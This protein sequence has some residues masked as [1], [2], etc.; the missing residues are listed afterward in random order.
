MP[1]PG[2][3]FVL[4]EVRAAALN[5]ADLMS[6]VAADW[7]GMAIESV[8]AFEDPHPPSTG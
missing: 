3:G 1:R 2:P 8:H 4:V 7:I 6:A 5:R